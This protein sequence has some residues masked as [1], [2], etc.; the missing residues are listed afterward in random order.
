MEPAS[1]TPPWGTELR[2]HG[3]SESGFTIIEVL[4]ALMILGVASTTT[5]TLLS[6]ATR[7]AQRAKASQVALEY[8]EQ[9]LEYLR[10]LENKNLALTATP[11]SSSEPLSPNYR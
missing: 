1:A 8:A 4:V 2:R 6:S 9:E 7:N 11:P 10:S 5:F 3:N